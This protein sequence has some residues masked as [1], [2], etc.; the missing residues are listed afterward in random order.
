MGRLV[1]LGWHR[2]RLHWLAAAYL[3]LALPCA[4]FLP[5]FWSRALT[6]AWD[7]HTHQY[8]TERAILNVTVET[9]SGINRDQRGPDTQAQVELRSIFFICKH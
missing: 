5:D 9:L 4:G 6:L 7:S 1:G 8:I 2:R 3:L